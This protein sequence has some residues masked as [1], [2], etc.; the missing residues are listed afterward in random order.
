V[1]DNPDAVFQ[2]C[3]AM[4]KHAYDPLGEKAVLGAFSV[5]GAVGKYT[6]P[7]K[8]ATTPPAPA[9][10]VNEP[11]GRKNTASNKR[12]KEADHRP[13]KRGD[14]RKL[15]L[16]S[17][18]SGAGRTCHFADEKQQCRV[19]TCRFDHGERLAMLTR[20]SASNSRL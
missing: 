11:R 3:G 7:Q 5:V 20:A 2:R 16:R 6:L 14:P 12:R 8:S 17:D 9:T 19:G 4:M 18:G 15:E 13:S 1:F 10:S